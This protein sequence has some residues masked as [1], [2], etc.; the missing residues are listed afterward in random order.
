MNNFYRG[1]Q[2]CYAFLY[3]SVWEGEN[4][5]IFYY[6]VLYNNFE[7][8]PIKYYNSSLDAGKLVTAKAHQRTILEIQ[9][10]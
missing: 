7:E 6:R 5:L 8:A 10:F 3:Q 9:K 4:S 2:I 1:F